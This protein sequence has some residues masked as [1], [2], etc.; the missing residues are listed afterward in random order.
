MG[1]RCFSIT[2]NVRKRVLD[3]RRSGW[4]NGFIQWR[5]NRENVRYKKQTKVVKVAITVIKK[6]LEVPQ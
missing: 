5:A 3:I 2:G 4:R 1:Q 6:Q